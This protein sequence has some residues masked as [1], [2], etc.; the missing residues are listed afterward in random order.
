MREKDLKS[1][2]EGLGDLAAQAE[3]D[4]EI[5]M[6]RSE[7]YKIAKYAIKLHEMLKGRSEEQGLEAWQQSKITKAADYMGSVYHN[8]EYEMKFGA[9][10]AESTSVAEG[11]AHGYNVAKWYEKNGDQIKLTKWLRK[12]AGL[13]KDADVYF[14][15]AD[16]VYGNKTIVP[17]ALVN[18]KL[19]FNDLLTALVKVTGGASKEKVDGVYR[20]Q[21]MAEEKQKGVDGKACWDGYK[22]MGTK[23][24]G[25]K[26]VDNCVKEDSYKDILAQRLD[27]KSKSKAQQKFMGM[28]YAAKKGEKPASKD[29]AKVAKGMSKSDAKDFASTKH[30]GKPEH[31]AETK[32][33][34]SAE[35]NKIVKDTVDALPP[36]A[37]IDAIER[38]LYSTIQ[39]IRKQLQSQDSDSFL[40]GLNRGFQRFAISKDYITRQFLGMTAE[41]LGLPGLYS[42]PEGNSFIYV[43]KDPNGG[44]KSARFASIEDAIKL[45]QA[46]YVTKEKAQELQADNLNNPAFKEPPGQGSSSG[47]KITRGMGG[48][49]A[50]DDELGDLM[51]TLPGQGGSGGN[52]NSGSS[53]TGPIGNADNNPTAVRT[54]GGGDPAAQ[55]S[56]AITALAKANNIKNP[57]L[58]KVGQTIKLPNG[59]SYTVA[60]GDT[61][62]GISSNK[63]KGQAPQ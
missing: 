45:Y 44:Y 41:K 29:V 8:L 58:I 62:S 31:V 25:G 38:S 56:K 2:K 63:F 59:K 55:F 40:Q 49:P 52:P 24:K 3:M 28:V 53:M 11:S 30:K 36:N 14:D 1:I 42:M 57:N 16:L 20:S 19:K 35:V 32:L 9:Q 10:M 48:A 37:N 5:Q 33:V 34:E 7:L 61:L 51:K 47:Q 17:S 43:D 6:A 46:G 21:D 22:R 18:P 23:K 50:S 13:P 54:G 12:E 26:T 39:F 15:D 27:E 60:K 4:H